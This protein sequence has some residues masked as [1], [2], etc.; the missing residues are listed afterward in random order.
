MFLQ[1]PN[2]APQSMFSKSFQNHHDAWLI[3]PTN[4]PTGCR[5]SGSWVVFKGLLWLRAKSHEA[6]S[7]KQSR[8]ETGRQRTR[9][10]KWQILVAETRNIPCAQRELAAPESKEL[11]RFSFYLLLPSRTERFLHPKWDSGWPWWF[12]IGSKPPPSHSP[13]FPD[14]SPPWNNAAWGFL[15]VTVQTIPL[16][17]NVAP[18]TPP[19]ENKKGGKSHWGRK[20]SLSNTKK[21]L[22]YFNKK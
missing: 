14:N 18:L 15:G 6:T 9:E 1:K 5:K 3:P 10:P 16:H 4:R 19:Q 17:E 12:C 11:P 2:S 7:W 22:I 8:H 21:K 13:S 20:Y